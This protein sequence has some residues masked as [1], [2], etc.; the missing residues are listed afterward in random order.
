[1]F[2]DVR[3]TR[4]NDNYAVVNLLKMIENRQMGNLDRRSNRSH[5][6][7][8]LRSAFLEHYT[9]RTDTDIINYELEAHLALVLS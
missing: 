1:M 7:S 2:I 5:L 9:C 3:A 4:L 6:V 8:V